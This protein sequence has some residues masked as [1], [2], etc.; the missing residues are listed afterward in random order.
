MMSQVLYKIDTLRTNVEYIKNVLDDEVSYRKNLR[1]VEKLETRRAM[2]GEA[3]EKEVV[4]S[5]EGNEAFD[6]LRPR[7]FWPEISFV[8]SRR[9]YEQ[10]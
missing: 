2:S 3:T 4:A 10:K 8:K 1:R 9:K 7:M 5:D 6:S